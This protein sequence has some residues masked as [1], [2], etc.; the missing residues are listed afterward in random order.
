[1]GINIY[2][3]VVQKD[4][5]KHKKGYC[6]KIDKEIEVGKIM[7]IKYPLDWNQLGVDKESFESI[8]LED[9]EIVKIK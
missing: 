8:E 1:M 4:G 7:T 9:C 3:N 2:V 6:L 5:L